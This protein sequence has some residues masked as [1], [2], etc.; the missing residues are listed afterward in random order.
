MYVWEPLLKFVFSYKPVFSRPTLSSPTQPH[1]QEVDEEKYLF[2]MSY[3]SAY[4]L[5]LQRCARFHDCR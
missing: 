3:S 2:V 5:P 4:R 1:V